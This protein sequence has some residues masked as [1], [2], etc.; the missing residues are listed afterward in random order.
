MGPSAEAQSFVRTPHKDTNPMVSITTGER[1]MSNLFVS[2][3]QV[4]SAKDLHTS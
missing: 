2:G 1:R 4:P 3:L